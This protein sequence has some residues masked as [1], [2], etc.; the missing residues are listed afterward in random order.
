MLISPLT[1]SADDKPKPP[2][3]PKAIQKLVDQLGSDDFDTREQAAKHLLQLDEAAL[4]ALKGAAKSAP[5]AEVRQRATEL[6]AT[7]TAH[8]EERAVEK[9]IAEVNAIGLEK[10]IE[11]MAKEKD[12]ATPAH[13]QLAARIGEAVARRSSDVGNRTVL[14][15]K[16]D[17]AKMTDLRAMPETDASQARI[18]LNNDTSGATLLANCLVVCNGSLGRVNTFNNCIL[19]VNG[20]LEGFRV[21][22]NCV[23]LCRGSIGRS[24]QID[25]SV[26]L[27]TGNLG[28]LRTIHRSLIETASLG[29]CR[30]SINSIYVNQAQSPASDSTDDKCIQTKRGPL[31]MFRWA[32]PQE[33]KKP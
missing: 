23:V 15:P 11:K 31:Q 16:L 10:F 28:S 5:D 1:L 30:E 9:T 29:S 24:T 18:V 26:V 17:L 19:I 22:R 33:E 21:M 25:T 7:I 13:W 12:Y 27:A 6:A 4:P 8:V 2:P 20:D 3:D 14:A 32:A